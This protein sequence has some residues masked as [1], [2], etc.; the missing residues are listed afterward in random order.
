MKKIRVEVWD[1]CLLVEDRRMGEFY[2]TVDGLVS[3]QKLK[4][5][6]LD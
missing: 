2:F 4:Y 3:G 6:I 1:Y 5:A